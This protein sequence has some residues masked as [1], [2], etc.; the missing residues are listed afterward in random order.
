[1]VILGYVACQYPVESSPGL[2]SKDWREGI[3]YLVPVFTVEVVGM[4]EYFD[5]FPSKYQRLPF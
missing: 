5:G 2:M 1:V 3:A 4:F